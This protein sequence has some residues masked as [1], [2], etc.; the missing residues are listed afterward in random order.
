MLTLRLFCIITCELE[1]RQR[2]QLGGC[3]SSPVEL[4][5]GLN[6]DRDSGDSGEDTV[7][8]HIGARESRWSFLVDESQSLIHGA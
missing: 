8:S 4:R 5:E 6:E 3:G 7:W 2:D 1:H